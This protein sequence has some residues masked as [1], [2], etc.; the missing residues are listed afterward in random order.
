M[1]PTTQVRGWPLSDAAILNYAHTHE[2]FRSRSLSVAMSDEEYMARFREIIPVG[3]IGDVF[4]VVTPKTAAR[5][6]NLRVEYEQFPA[7]PN[8]FRPHYTADSV[9]LQKNTGRIAYLTEDELTESF[10]EEFP[11]TSWIRLKD[12]LAIELGRWNYGK[13]VFKTVTRKRGRPP[14]IANATPAPTPKRGRGRP[15]RD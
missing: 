7:G 8:G 1:P 2:G 5:I 12:V 9:R 10:G 14:K 13:R 15:K 3:S 11:R 6:Y 4:G